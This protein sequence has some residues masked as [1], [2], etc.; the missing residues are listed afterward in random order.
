ML[1]EE[2][3]VLGLQGGT[4]QADRVR[5]PGRHD[6]DQ[7]GDVGEDR[8][9]ALGVPDRPAGQVAADRDPQHHRA[10]ER[11]V[12]PPPDGGRLGLDLLHGGPDVV[13][14]LH[15]GHRPQAPEALAHGPADD[16][17]LGQRGVVAAGQ[18]EA[19]LETEGSAEHPALALHVGQH[20][21]PGV[22][23][24]L[25]EHPDA[26]VLRHLLVEGAL[27]GLA[28]GDDL[29]RAVVGALGGRID[30][31]Q[32]HHLVG[33]AGRVGPGGGDGP[34]GGRQ[35]RLA[36]VLL[37]LGHLVGRH[38]AAFEQGLLHQHQRIVGGLLRQ[39]IRRAV[40][41]LGVG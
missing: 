10:A 19:A 18:P 13:E 35:H 16:V 22:G 33:D 39:L 25:P 41:A 23:D 24:V 32:R 2:N 34:A 14:E 4:E 37:D 11:P 6:D 8:L 30:I 40:L 26:L 20:R 9:A 21:L 15:L 31:G 36:G 29:A 7:A 1:E 5:G 28:E 3:R 17:G 27:D 38:H 12:R